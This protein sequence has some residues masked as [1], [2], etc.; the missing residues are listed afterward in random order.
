[1]P[2]DTIHVEVGGAGSGTRVEASAVIEL[3]SLICA[4]CSTRPPRTP[5]PTALV[6]RAA[7]VWG[8]G[9]PM[10]AEQV[11]LADAVGM[12][13]DLDI[14]PFLS[15]LREPIP[16]PEDLPLETE[17]PDE[18]TIINDRLRRLA[19]DRWLRVRY[20]DVLAELWEV[21]AQ[22]WESGGRDDA[23]GVADE[24]RR[25]IRHGTDPLELLREQHVARRAPYEEMARRAH[26]NGTL[27]LTPTVAGHYGHI[28]ALPGSLSLSGGAPVVDPA[29]ARRK[30]ATEIAEGLRVLSEPT[31]L[32][33][34]SQLAE[35]PAA[36]GELAGMLHVSQP[37]VSAHLRRLRE[38]GFVEARRR[39]STSVYSLRPDAVIGR[40]DGLSARLAAS[41]SAATHLDPEV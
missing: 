4:T 28:I 33:I 27:R 17:V 3:S 38:A 2:M 37:T 25:M 34:L 41:L 13:D 9:H 14:E 8:D 22:R 24:W 40:L 36:V 21:F 11:V 15:R 5:I 23:R 39:G 12:L 18:R 26:L 30:A 20:A 16:F 1:M 31:R 29:V 10:L 32:T 19:G 7:R 6:E 35:A